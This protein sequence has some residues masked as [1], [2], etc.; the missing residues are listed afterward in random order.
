M[1]RIFKYLLLFF[2]LVLTS[3]DL[4][5]LGE[6]IDFGDDISTSSSSSSDDNSSTS[7]GGLT[8]QNVVKLLSQDEILSN[9]QAYSHSFSITTNIGVKT[10][11]VKY[12]HE[13]NSGIV[14]YQYD[15]SEG[16]TEISDTYF[17]RDFDNTCLTYQSADEGKSFGF[18][19][20]NYLA[21][22]EIR[23]L[24]DYSNH[25]IKS[26]VPYE[27]KTA[28]TYADRQAT[29]YVI[30]D[31]ET[32]MTISSKM[33]LITD[34]ETGAILSINYEGISVY[35][36]TSFI[37]KNESVKSEVLNRKDS[38]VFEYFDKRA[39]SVFNLQDI[40]FPHGFLAGAGISF[41]DNTNYTIP[42]MSAYNVG[43]QYLTE[44][45][46]FIKELC[47]YVFDHVFEKD[48][49]GEEYKFED[50]YSEQT[51]NYPSA[52]LTIKRVNCYVTIKGVEYLVKL[53]G[54]CNNTQSNFWF[55]H[56]NINEII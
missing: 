56:L 41:R 10:F 54:Q 33:Y 16:N 35:D 1:N 49:S 17:L 45:T 32:I 34:D 31:Q 12:N 3:C 23:Y 48:E 13:T 51:V 5:S 26:D 36:T 55:V 53:Q 14:D 4:S 15:S 37:P 22:F 9:M 40:V 2:P 50:F 39:L 8:N 27:S 42:N 29:R 18:S 38:L 52:M 21:L 24:Y 7:S 43:Y 28:I 11:D 25:L 19:K 6:D 47:Q 46:S 44:D 30:S 20:G